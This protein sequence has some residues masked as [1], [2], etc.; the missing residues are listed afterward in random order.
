MT[1]KSQVLRVGTSS[2][3]PRERAKRIYVDP[4]AASKYRPVRRQ[5]KSGKAVPASSTLPASKAILRT[6]AF[7]RYS[8][9]VM[10]RLDKATNGTE[11]GAGRGIFPGRSYTALS[12]TITNNSSL[13]IDVNQVVVT[14]EYGSPA[15][16]APPHVRSSICCGFCRHT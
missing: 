15:R 8:D 5:G 13:P 2:A 11:K 6:Q 3:G 14:T 16:I 12:F 1:D 4:E 10:V 9:R 7:V